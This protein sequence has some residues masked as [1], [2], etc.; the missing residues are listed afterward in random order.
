VCPGPRYPAG[1]TAATI[2]FCGARARET[3]V[4]VPAITQRAV[5]AATQPRGRRP[6]RPG[7]LNGC[8]KTPI[9]GTATH[10]DAT[11]PQIKPAG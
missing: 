10:A 6:G 11:L 3:G 5:S 8:R 7:G 9:R 4:T 1:M 2:T